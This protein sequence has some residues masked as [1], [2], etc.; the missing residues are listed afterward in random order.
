MGRSS[1]SGGGLVFRIVTVTDYT[2]YNYGDC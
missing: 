2:D 1:S